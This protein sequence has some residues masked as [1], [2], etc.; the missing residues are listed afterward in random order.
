MTCSI[1][2]TQNLGTFESVEVGEV[3]LKK[4]ETHKL[5]LQP[6]IDAWHPVTIRGLE[7]V[8]VD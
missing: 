7:L 4:G 3:K 1:P 8:P 2:K 6:A 5:V